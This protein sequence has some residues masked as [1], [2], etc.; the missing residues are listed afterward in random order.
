MNIVAGL[1]ADKP[2]EPPEVYKPICGHTTYWPLYTVLYQH[3]EILLA[4]REEQ[5]WM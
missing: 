5:D 4:S 1:Y 3:K 2:K